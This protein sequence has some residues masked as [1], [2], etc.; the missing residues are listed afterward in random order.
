GVLYVDGHVRAYHGEQ[1]KLPER[2]SSR[3]RLCVRS[4]MDYWVCDRDGKPFFVVTSMGTEGMIH[5]LRTNIIPRLLAEVP[6][7]PTEAE[8]AA[9]PDLHRFLIVFDREGYCAGQADPGLGWL[10]T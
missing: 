7:Q 8:L 6:N 3:D 4:L 9:N 2:F 10:K 1:T 5:H